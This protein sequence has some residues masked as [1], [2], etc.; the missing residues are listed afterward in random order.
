M[1]LRFTKKIRKRRGYRTHGYGRISQHRKSGQK[2]GKGAAGYK[3]HWK[4]WLIKN[5]PD[6]FGKHGFK[7]P[8]SVTKPINAINLRELDKII[9]GKIGIQKTGKSKTVKIDLNKLGYQ[10]LLSKGSLS[11]P[12]KIIV[13]RATKSAIS[14]DESIGGKVITP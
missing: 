8:A 6:Y 11:T 12:A 14:K 9:V 7:R 4:S 13:Q 1:S 3:K 5:M 2:G 10:K